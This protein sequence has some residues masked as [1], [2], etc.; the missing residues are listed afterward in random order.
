MKDQ[1][2]H[3]QGRRVFCFYSIHLKILY[4]SHGTFKDMLEDTKSTTSHWYVLL[5]EIYEDFSILAPSSSLLFTVF[6]SVLFIFTSGI[7][8]HKALIYYS[9]QVPPAWSLKRCNLFPY[10]VV[11]IGFLNICFKFFLYQN[12]RS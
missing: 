7:W 2:L 11:T 1:K 6:S 9:V 5:P 10:F 3:T 12:I 4:F 8:G